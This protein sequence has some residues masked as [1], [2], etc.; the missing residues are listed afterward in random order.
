MSKVSVLILRAAGINCDEE[1]AHAF[2]L[3]GAERVDPVH[4]NAFIQGR[5]RLSEYDVLVLSGGFSYGDDLSGGKVLANEMQCKLMEDVE[6]FI[7]EG[8]LILGICNGFQVLV[9]MGL[10]PQTE[11][12][13]RRQEATVFYNDS[14]KFECRWVYLRR[15]P[16]SPCVFTRDMPETIYIPVANGE[17][18]VMLASED[19]RARLGPGGHVA[20]QYV[21]P[22]WTATGKSAE[23]AAG[24]ASAAAAREAAGVAT[25]ETTYPWSPNGSVDAIA[26]ICDATGRIFGLMPHPER[27][28]HPTHHPRWTREGCREPDGLHIFRNA[29]NYVRGVQ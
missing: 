3:A 25:G 27:Y 26:G 20:L 28:T 11:P 10:L 9:K 12:G 7:G 4:I 24:E 5:R 18:K 17:G 19:V 1:T 2:R 15:N 21:N 22:P 6:T 29:V 23:E 16:G 13:G 14:G 8:K